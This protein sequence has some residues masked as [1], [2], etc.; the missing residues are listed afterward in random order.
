MI[1][2]AMRPFLDLGKRREML[3]Y[4]VSQASWL[5]SAFK[6]DFIFLVGLLHA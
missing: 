1:F 2:T 3:L 5:F 6:V 4:K